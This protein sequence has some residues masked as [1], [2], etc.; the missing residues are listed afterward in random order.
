MLT[1]ARRG[2][3]PYWRQGAAPP[4]GYASDGHGGLIVVAHEQAVVAEA[5][6]LHAT[7][8]SFRAVG[9]ALEGAGFYP[10]G[11]DRWHPNQIRRIVTG[12]NS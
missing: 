4:Y 5:R 6:R 1:P 3:H 11:R 10:R 7:G 2:P 12:R 8:L 9:A